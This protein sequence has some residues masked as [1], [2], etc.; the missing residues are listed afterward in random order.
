[1]LLQGKP[2]RKEAEAG[3]LLVPA[4]GPCHRDHWYRP[5]GR[6]PPHG[7]A[8]QRDLL[9]HILQFL[10]PGALALDDLVSLLFLLAPLGLLEQGQPLPKLHHRHFPFQAI[11]RD[12]QGDGESRSLLSGPCP[13][14]TAV[15]CALTC[16]MHQHWCPS[17]KF[18]LVPVPRR[19]PCLCSVAPV[20]HVSLS[21][22]PAW[23][24]L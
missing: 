1:M 2:A 4:G 17:P 15:S 18:R 5:Q 12:L 22:S 16:P 10:A 20:Y 24:P 6:R 13:A 21:V 3:S 19:P 23:A 14:C 8:A 7:C 11:P 9:H